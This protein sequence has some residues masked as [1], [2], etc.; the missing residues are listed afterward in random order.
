MVGKEEGKQ[1]ASSGNVVTQDWDAAWDS[2]EENPLPS[3]SNRASLDEE[4]RASEVTS[5][6]TTAAA[7]D[8]AID[9][10]GWGDDTD[11]PIAE[12]VDQPAS[13][14]SQ[15][16]AQNGP[17][18]REVTLSER[19]HSSSMPQPVFNTVAGIFKD[20]A[21]LTTSEC[22]FHH[23]LPLPHLTS[24]TGS[25]NLPSHLQHQGCSTYPP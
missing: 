25:I 24:L 5:A 17:D 8:D 2:E 22:V 12:V 19:Y 7:D 16:H 18:T 10:W 20:G 3:A 4:R 14:E 1:I 6:A 9:A 23:N 11:D 21:R 13:R 15:L